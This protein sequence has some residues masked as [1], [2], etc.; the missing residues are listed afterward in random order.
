MRFFNRLWGVLTA[1]P[2]RLKSQWELALAAVFGLMVSLSLIMSIPLYADAVYYRSLQK[3][4]IEDSEFGVRARPP[5]T[6]LMHYY[7]GW[8]NHLTWEDLQPVDSYLTQSA[9]NTLELPQLQLV[10]YINTDSFPLLPEG[11]FNYT[12][13]MKVVRGNLGTMTGLQEH[14]NI[15]DGEFPA[16]EDPGEGEPVEVLIS[17]KMASDN[18]YKVGD[19]YQFVA[20]EGWFQESNELGRIPVRIAGIWE[21]IDAEESYWIS[22]P[23]RYDTVLFTSEEAFSGTVDKTI[24]QAVFSAYWYFVMDGSKVFSGDVQPLLQRIHRLE[25]TAADNLPK[26]KLRISPVEALTKYQRSANLLTILLYAFSVPIVGLILAFI[27]LVARL[28]VERQR[29]EIA[30]MRSRGASPFQVLSF[31]IVEGL[32]LGL[33][34]LILSLPVAVTL[35]RWSRP[36][37]CP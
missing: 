33:V 29:N 2:Y 3:T 8:A 10:R 18:G 1:V 17:Q 37:A 28:S 12:P 36:C 34:A 22:A 27:G 24:P 31:S 23:T 13:G 26:I 15:L 5:F 7:G 19:T 9:S 16:V 30:V 14:I 20:S 6:F 25:Q 35:T 4:I 21:P 11:D 32:I